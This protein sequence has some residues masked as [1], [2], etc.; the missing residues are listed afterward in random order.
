MLEN[1]GSDP[2]GAGKFSWLNFTKDGN[3]LHGKQK[4]EK[5]NTGTM[6]MGRGQSNA[7]GAYDIAAK[8]TPLIK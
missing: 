4:L 3:R 5:V 1:P 6:G 7:N 2:S 8:G